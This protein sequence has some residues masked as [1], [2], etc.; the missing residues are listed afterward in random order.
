LR[1]GRSGSI[2]RGPCHRLLF[3]CLSYG[4]LGMSHLLGALLLF[5][6]GCAQLGFCRF[7]LRASGFD[8]AVRLCE[9]LCD[10]FDGPLKLVERVC[11]TQVGA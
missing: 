4:S 8:S 6:S 5:R 2:E 3:P 7:Q 10:R 1:G 11:A 9:R